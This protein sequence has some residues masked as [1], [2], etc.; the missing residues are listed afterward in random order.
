MAKFVVELVYGQ[1]NDRR[2]EARPAHREYSKQL[3]ADG[4]LLV[5]GPYTDERGAMLVY[6][7]ADRD[8]LQRVLDD[9]P[10]TQAGV[11]AET[12][13]REWNPVTGGWL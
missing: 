8:A 6:D 11:V 5:G 3:A 13:V 2:L 9:D 7:V 1:D 4:V 12:T 10:Y